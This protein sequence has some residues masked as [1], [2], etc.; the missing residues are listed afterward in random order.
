[1][2]KLITIFSFALLVVSCKKDIDTLNKETKRPTDV[3]PGSLFANAQ[4]KLVDQLTSSNV[5]QNIFRLI[6]QYWT[7]TTYT[8]ES[9]YDLGTRNIPQ[10][11]WD[12]MFTRSVKNLAEAARL[13]PTQDP[14]YVST[15][16]IKNQAAITEIMSVYTYYVLVSVYGNIPYSKALDINNLTPAYD[17]AAARVWPKK[18]KHR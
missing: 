18:H 3:T 14:T 12:T 9:N 1:M 11:L 5:N 8:D 2:K 6:S 17:D 4:K 16:T 10:N 7:E 13:I 15:T